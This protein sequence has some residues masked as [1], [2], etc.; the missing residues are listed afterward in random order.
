MLYGGFQVGPNARKTPNHT[1]NRK[2]Q[3]AILPVA[4]DESFHGL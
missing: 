4:E 3:V 2:K 1:T